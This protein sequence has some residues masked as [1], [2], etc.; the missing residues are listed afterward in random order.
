MSRNSISLGEFHVHHKKFTI[1]CRSETA[2]VYRMLITAL[3]QLCSLR[4]TVIAQS[5]RSKD[6]EPPNSQQLEIRMTKAEEGLL[7]E[8]MDVAKEFLKKGEKEEALKVLKR[9]EHINPKME[10]LQAGDGPDQRRTDA[11]ERCDAGDGRFEILGQ[12][13]L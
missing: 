3:L 7:K 6:K 5:S 4:Q 12:C 2:L 1:D 9:V 10:G 13:D 8:Y 11:G